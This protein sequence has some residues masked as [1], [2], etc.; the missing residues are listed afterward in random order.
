MRSDEKRSSAM[1]ML[2]CI[3]ADPALAVGVRRQHLVLEHV[4]ERRAR[5]ARPAPRRRWSRRRWPSRSRRA[6]TPPAT[7]RRGWSRFSTPFIAAF[8]PE[9][10]HASSGRMGLFSQTSAPRVRS[11]RAPCRSRGRRRPT[12]DSVRAIATRLADDL[13][14]PSSS[15]GWALPAN[16]SWS[17]RPREQR[18]DA[19]AIVEDQVA[20]L[21][22][23]G[24]ARE[25][26]GEHVG[27]EADAGAGRDLRRAARACS[28]W[29]AAQRPLGEPRASRMRASCQV[30]DVHAVGDRDDRARARRR[31]AT[32]RARPRRGARRRRWR[33]ATSRRPATVM[34][35]GSPPIWRISQSTSS[36][37]APEPPQLGERV[38]LVAG[39]DRGVGRE[40]DLLAHRAPRRRRTR[41]PAAM[42][43]AISSTPA[44]TACPSLKW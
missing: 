31:R 9:V 32:W 33:A 24:A 41:A 29:C 35:K 19:L 25:A 43:S 10:P 36:Q 40:H 3:I 37:Q 27:V 22:G 5:R 14:C 12:R 39:G 4:V 28:A 8:M 30:G 7:S 18:L 13:P 44:K 23:G 16:T 34:L 15:S 1:A 21:V 6:G 11:G 42:R 2:A 17:R 38:H 20:A 26:D